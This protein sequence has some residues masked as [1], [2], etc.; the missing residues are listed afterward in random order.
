M[1]SASTNNPY[2]NSNC[3]YDQNYGNTDDPEDYDSDTLDY[4]NEN[5]KTNKHRAKIK[6]RYLQV[7]SKINRNTKH[8][9]ENDHSEFDEDLNETE[10]ENNSNEDDI[11]YYFKLQS[12]Q[13]N[14]NFNNIAFNFNNN[15][16]SNNNDNSTLIN[17]K[18]QIEDTKRQTKPII[19]STNSASINSSS[20]IK[21]PSLNKLPSLAPIKTSSSFSKP[22]ELPT[23]EYPNINPFLEKEDNSNNPFSDKEMDESNESKKN[24]FLDENSNPFLSEEKTLNKD[25]SILNSSNTSKDLLDWCKDVIKKTKSSSPCFNDLTLNDFSTSWTSGLAFCAIIYHF[26][27][28]LMCL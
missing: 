16:N 1:S 26:K 21:L 11:D 19:K 2:L 20:Q 22:K 18:P 4:H 10:N 24:P 27:P 14:S 7:P 8:F 5:S 28:D 17:K 6:A 13:I 9:S 25:F 12:K 23:V 3:L 15:N